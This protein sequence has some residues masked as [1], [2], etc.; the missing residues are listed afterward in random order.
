MGDMTLMRMISPNQ[1]LVSSHPVQ[2]E[3]VKLSFCYQS[4]SLCWSASSKLPQ[5]NVS[6]DLNEQ[7]EPH[8]D[9]F[10]H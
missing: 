3:T 5:E 10:T 4:P 8:L 9:F 2:S 6:G 1:A 7:L